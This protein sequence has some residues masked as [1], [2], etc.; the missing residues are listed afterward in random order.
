[1]CVPNE[2][3]V[4][5][6]VDRHGRPRVYHYHMK[7]TAI[8]MLV[9]F[10]LVLPIAA[11]ALTADE[12]RTQI[13]QLLAQLETLKQQI[14]QVTTQDTANII[15]TANNSQCFRPY[16]NLQRS[17][18]GSDVE[19]LQRFLLNTGDYT[20]G[21]ITGFFGSATEL[22]VQRFQCRNNITCS[23][24]PDD[25]GY[26]FVGARTRAAMSTRC[27]TTQ[28]TPP[29]TPTAVYQCPA[30]TQPA[31]GNGTLSSLGNDAGG[32]HRG[33]LCEVRTVVQNNAPRLEL[34]G[35]GSLFLN[36][37]GTWSVK[38]TDP[39]GDDVSIQMFFGDESAIDVI[40]Q[41][42]NP[43][44][45][46]AFTKTHAFSKVGTYSVKVSATDTA[47]NSA[48]I[49]SAV[50]VR[51]HSCSQSGTTIEHGA[52][53]TFY[54]HTNPTSGNTCMTVS[55]SRTCN[56]GA[57]SGGDAYQYTSC[58]ELPLIQTP[59]P[60]PSISSDP[61]SDSSCRVWGSCGWSCSRDTPGGTPRC[62]ATGT[63]C[64]TESAARPQTCG[65]YFSTPS[66]ITSGSC[67]LNGVSKPEGSTTYGPTCFTY[68]CS[69]IVVAP[70]LTCKAGQWVGGTGV[71]VC[72]QSGLLSPDYYGCNTTNTAFCT[73]GATRL[74]GGGTCGNQMGCYVQACRNAQWVNTLGSVNPDPA[75]TFANTPLGQYCGGLCHGVA[76][77]VS[78][79]L[80]SNPCTFSQSDVRL[81]ENIS[82]IPDALAKLS[83]L[84]GIFFTW[85]D[86]SISQEQQMGV[87][88]Q[89]VQK[90]FPEAVVENGGV[91]YVNYYSLIAPIV[92]ALKELKL[93]NDTL[94][95]ELDI[96]KSKQL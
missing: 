11:S 34:S 70:T 61:A 24:T 55:Q 63:A 91:L 18:R 37:Q 6:Q 42:A 26:G 88:A 52:S 35:P 17:M 39:E 68:G 1:M 90:V 93:Q 33:W 32:C 9:G 13:A 30:I 65:I 49:T 87:I 74:G 60:A 41:F 28:T 4:F 50:Q 31:C 56:N 5:T 22:A 71:S 23:G 2:C 20:Y 8:S 92:E 79:D 53:K 76:T 44:S 19:E 51:G 69:M 95:S 62:L 46:R 14:A 75:C 3:W 64:T 25:N 36:E 82:P 40:E 15:S 86:H 77:A 80:W 89:E 66:P 10:A 83:Q 67:T 85:K 58:K 27:S 16:R 43:T 96:L 81:K 59:A 48:S 54:S 45:A 12:I 78:Y 47:H 73:E 72:N 29:P 7:K 38:A 94:R 21:E 84:N 57:L